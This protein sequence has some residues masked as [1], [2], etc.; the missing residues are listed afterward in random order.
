MYWEIGT[1]YIIVLVSKK[2][3]ATTKIFTQAL[4]TFEKLKVSTLIGIH[5][6]GFDL[7]R[8]KSIFKVK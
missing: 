4:Q 1:Q 6:L 5:L 3:Q 8:L 2:A 7:N